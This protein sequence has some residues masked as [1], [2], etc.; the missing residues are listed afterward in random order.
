MK[1]AKEILVHTFSHVILDFIVGHLHAYF[2]L[3]SPFIPTN[4]TFWKCFCILSINF[5]GRLQ[6]YMSFSVDELKVNLEQLMYS[7]F[8]KSSCLVFV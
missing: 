4:I 7:T 3:T 6:L 8:G 5:A 2:L 1:G